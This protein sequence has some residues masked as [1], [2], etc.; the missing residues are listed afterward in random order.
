[1][2]S[3]VVGL[4]GILF[5]D[6]PFRIPRAAAYFWIYIVLAIAAWGKVMLA[7]LKYPTADISREGFALMLLNCLQEAFG[8]L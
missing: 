2:V 4:S 3:G 6:N 5:D 8:F 7:I 1:M